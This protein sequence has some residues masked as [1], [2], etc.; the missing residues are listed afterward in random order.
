MAESS[1]HP[2]LIFFEKG[3]DERL[4]QRVVGKLHGRRVN[5]EKFKTFVM[6]MRE[7][8]DLLMGASPNISLMFYPGNG[9]SHTMLPGFIH[10]PVQ[11][12][13]NSLGHYVKEH[14]NIC[15]RN[16]QDHC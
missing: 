2:S 13:S 9:Y 8:S 10:V 4:I 15:R 16:A 11:F 7:I 6:Q 14:V 12:T 3:M 5:D 1:I